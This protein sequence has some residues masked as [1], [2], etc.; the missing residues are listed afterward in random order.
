ME[1]NNE[2]QT[3]NKKKQG[4]V[5]VFVFIAVVVFAVVAAWFFVGRTA[6]PGSKV[7]TTSVVT[8]VPT[9]IPVPTN[10]VAVDAAKTEHIF[11]HPLLAYLAKA[12]DGDKMQKGLDEY[13]VTVPEFNKIIQSLYD[14]NYILVNLKDV[15]VSNPNSSTD[16]K[17]YKMNTLMLPKDK[18]PLVISIDDM[19][20]YKYMIDNG[21]TDKLVFDDNGNIAALS[22]PPGGPDSITRDNDIIPL[23]DD[24]V[25][26]HPDFSWNGTKG[27]I[28]ETGYDGVLGYRTQSGSPNRD[29]EIAAVKPIIQRLKDTGWYFGSHGYAHLSAATTKVDVLKAD[30]KQW[31]DEV[32]SL[33]GPTTLYIYPYGAFPVPNNDK[34][35]TY[36]VLTDAG[37]TILAGVGNGLYYKV[38]SKSVTTQRAH[39]DG[40]ALKTQANQYLRFFDANTLIDPMRPK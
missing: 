23:L 39:I 2:Q 8:S 11:F 28:A 6:A 9:T 40:I 3:T 36:Q 35:P 37:F 14:K 31:L 21:T 30:T 18:K 26:A 33:V 29:T 7:G 15:L 22:S 4:W 12:F 38:E 17:Q 10:L 24:F 27:C 19:N 34:S 20:Y 16:G 25:K 32:G 5:Y 13:F 1:N